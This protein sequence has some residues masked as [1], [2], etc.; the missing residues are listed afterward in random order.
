MAL[1]DK[2]F[3]K[4]KSNQH[5]RSP[6]LPPVEEPIDISFA[7]NFTSKGGHFL[8]CDALPQVKANYD[9]ICE[10]NDWDNDSVVCLEKSLSDRFKS[11]LISQTS[12]S[13]KAFNAALISCEYLISNTGKILLSEHQIKHFK[14]SELPNTVI[15][16]A[17][18][19]QLVKDVSQ[20]MTALKNKYAKTI[21]TN[22]TSLKTKSSDGDE[23]EIENLNSSAKNIY[24]LLE[25]VLEL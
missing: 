16:F 23:N 13:L 9:N 22:I 19:E 4:K 25:D 20:G 12:G 15:L 17:K 6:Y 18:T 3:G 10:E 5:E 24:L 14:L 1:W 11:T 8:Y 2:F 7:K 21:P